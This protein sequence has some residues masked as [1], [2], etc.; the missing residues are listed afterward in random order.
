VESKPTKMD[1]GFCFLYSKDMCLFLR[2]VCKI[3]RTE[4]TLRN[5][6]EC[7][8]FE[9]ENVFLCFQF[10]VLLRRRFN[11]YNDMKGMLVTEIVT[12]CRHL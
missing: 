7:C 3:L 9:F 11:R 12:V 5:A 4:A 2:I 1:A 6:E 8:F 10:C